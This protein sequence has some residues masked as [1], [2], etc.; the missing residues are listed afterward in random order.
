M[1]DRLQLLREAQQIT[2]GIIDMSSALNDERYYDL[3]EEGITDQE[4]IA[5]LA[6]EILEEARSYYREDEYAE[7]F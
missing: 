2:H 6:G 1:K 5:R 7:E 3:R 4:I